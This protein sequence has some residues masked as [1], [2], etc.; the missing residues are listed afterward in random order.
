MGEHLGAVQ[1]LPDKA[2]KGEFVQVVPADLGGV[3]VF[4]L[5]ALHDLRDVGVVAEGVGQPEAV[6]GIAEVFTGELLALQKLADHQ[7]AGGDVAV[8]FHIYA[9]V[10]LIAALGDPLLHL[11]KDRGVVILHPFAV[12]GGGL[13]KPVFGV[14]LH[15]PEGVGVGPRALAHGLADGPQPRGVHVGMADHAHAAE[16]AVVFA[17]KERPCDLER[18]FHARHNGFVVGMLRI[19]AEHVVDLFERL[20]RPR[21]RKIGVRQL[22]GGAQKLADIKD[23]RK[24]I[25]VAG[26]NLDPVEYVA[27]FRHLHIRKIVVVVREILN[28]EMPRVALKAQRQGFACLMSAEPLACVAAADKVAVFGVEQALGRAV[29]E[30]ELLHAPAAGDNVEVLSGKRL[31]HGKAGAYPEVLPL[32][33][34]GGPFFKG[35][36]AGVRRRAQMLLRLQPFVGFGF[37]DL[38]VDQPLVD[39]KHSFELIKNAV[40]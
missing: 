5:A 3:E 7:L 23:Q 34:P 10:G 21:A 25:L 12:E 28:A 14:L 31:G 39:R 9:A 11:R 16:N 20:F 2:F 36:K 29:D 1:A 35:R 13:D 26:A 22:L 33:A 38:F 32:F 30:K 19:K 37:G 27:V 4:D 15:Q 17:F 40:L 24:D 8:A 6:G 18:R